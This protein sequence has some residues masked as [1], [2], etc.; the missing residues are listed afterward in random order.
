M[1]DSPPDMNDELMVDGNAVGGMLIDV[2]GT[3]MTAAPSKCASC[4][5]V[6]EIGRLRAYVQAP[7][8]VLRCP[9]CE[10]VVVRIAG[11]PKG[12]YLDARGA[13]YLLVG[14]R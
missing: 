14:R 4:G 11:S 3:E 1:A 8:A 13:E 7:G 2:F 12:W 5:N 10:N 6:A 9:T